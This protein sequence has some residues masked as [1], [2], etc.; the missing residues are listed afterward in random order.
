MSPFMHERRI[1]ERGEKDEIKK[2]RK[3]GAIIALRF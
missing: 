3:A 2:A 1:Y